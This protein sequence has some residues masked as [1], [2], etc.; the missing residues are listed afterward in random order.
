VL[1]TCLSEFENGGREEGGVDDCPFVLALPQ[2]VL[3]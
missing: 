1:A 3:G 2:K